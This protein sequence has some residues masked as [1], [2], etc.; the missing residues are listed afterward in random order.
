MGTNG[1]DLWM[2]QIS[3]DESSI[4]KLSTHDLEAFEDYHGVK[5]VSVSEA[6]KKELKKR[7]LPLWRL[8]ND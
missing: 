6:V 1:M 8:L 5:I 4:S 3:I 7:R 2:S